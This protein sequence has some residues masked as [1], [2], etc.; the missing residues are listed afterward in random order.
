MNPQLDSA[1]VYSALTMK[2]MILGIPTDMLIMMAFAG[3]IGLGLVG[4]NLL[5][6]I[7]GIAIFLIVLPF[8]RRLFEK[9]PLS[10]ELTGAYL[11]QWPDRLP[12]H[13]SV[14]KS[15]KSD[16]VLKGIYG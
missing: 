6:V 5:S 12:H 13:A 15:T 9:E 2:S 1:P 16:T 7:G 14:T 11:V 8:V 10:V 4:F 3:I